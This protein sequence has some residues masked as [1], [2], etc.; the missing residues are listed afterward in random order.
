[1]SLVYLYRLWFSQYQFSLWLLLSLY[2]SFPS[3]PVV[4]IFV[5]LYV[6]AVSRC[7]NIRAC[8]PYISCTSVPVGPIS[9]V[10][11]FLLSLYNLFHLFF[12]FLY[13]LFDL[14]LLSQYKLSI[15]SCCLYISCSIC[16]CLLFQARIG[17][18]F[19][20]YLLV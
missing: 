19:E 10:P 3:L 1:M 2:I 20:V 6:L 5:V 11:L 14:F 17:W 4:S 15:C 8:C 7:C 13:K 18:M 16:C 9:I 12:L